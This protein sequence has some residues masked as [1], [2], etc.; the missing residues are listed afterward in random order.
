MLLKLDYSGLVAAAA[1]AAV[2]VGVD[3]SHSGC[4][5]VCRPKNNGAIDPGS[6]RGFKPILVVVVVVTNLVAFLET[7]AAVV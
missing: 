7:V 6:H 4:Q 1:A 3:G 2:V 5:E